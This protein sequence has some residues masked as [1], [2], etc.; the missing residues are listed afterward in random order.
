MKRLEIIGVD[1]A[2][3]T[4]H[5]GLGNFR[6]V[7]VEDLTKHKMDSETNISLQKKLAIL[8]TLVKMLKKEFVQ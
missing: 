7:D 2:E 3:I 5:V 4:L 1:F 8:L 6:S